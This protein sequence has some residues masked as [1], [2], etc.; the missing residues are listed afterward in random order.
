MP[1][2]MTTK[3]LVYDFA[4]LSDAAKRRAIENYI[5]DYDFDLD[6]DWALDFL[7]TEKYPHIHDL[8][9]KFSGFWSQGDGASFTGELDS[10]WAVDAFLTTEEKTLIREIDCHFYRLERLTG[11]YLHRHTC[12]SAASIVRFADHIEEN[13]ALRVSIDHDLEQEITERLEQYRL[14]VCDEIYEFLRKTYEAQTSDEAAIER[15][16][17]DGTLFRESGEVFDHYH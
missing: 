2:V 16:H 7:A 11:R 6:L 12:T 4:E 17:C 8:N 5:N 3:V 1:Q 13:E 10:S 15:F 9:I 14:E